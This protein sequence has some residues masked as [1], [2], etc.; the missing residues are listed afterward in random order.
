MP[1][2]VSPRI[3]TVDDVLATANLPIGPVKTCEEHLARSSLASER[4]ASALVGLTAGIAIAL[5]VVGV[6]GAMADMV[7]RRR[8][9]LALRIALGARALGLV[10]QVVR[11]RLKLAGAGAAAGLVAALIAVS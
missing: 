10:M 1:L 11:Q 7:V 6:Y 3:R 2:P 9:E 8:R 5:S 4:V